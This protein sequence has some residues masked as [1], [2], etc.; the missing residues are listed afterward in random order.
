MKKTRDQR[1]REQK[2]ALIRTQQQT[3]RDANEYERLL[4]AEMRRQA[5]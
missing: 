1:K 4:L 2:K 3:R 5:K